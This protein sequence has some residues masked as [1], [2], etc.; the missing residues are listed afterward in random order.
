MIKCPK[1]LE[2]TPLQR[3]C[4]HCGEIIKHANEEMFDTLGEAVEN[5]LKNEVRERK[6]KKRLKIAAA[7]IIIVF[8]VYIGLKS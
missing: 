3:H 4:S 5:A 6:K 7:I 1:C 2:L 8:A